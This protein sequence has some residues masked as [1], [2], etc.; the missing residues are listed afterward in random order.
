[1]SAEQNIDTVKSLYE[2]FGRGD[3][4]A[5]L[6]RV[7]DDVEWATDAA[8]ES[9]PWYGPEHGKAEPPSFFEGIA[10]TGP[11]TEFTPLSCAFTVTAAGK[12]V[13][14]TPRPNARTDG[15][16]TPVSGDAV[17]LAAP[18]GIYS[19]SETPPAAA[20]TARASPGAG[21]SG[22]GGTTL[23]RL[24]KGRVAPSRGRALAHASV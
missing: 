5:I 13:A 8:I 11:V 14:G 19:R 3:V 1:M 12:D 17:T 2:A 9:A 20:R 10:K 16:R 15:G 6:E 4:D 24:R 21:A 7:T 23:A 22:S 18:A